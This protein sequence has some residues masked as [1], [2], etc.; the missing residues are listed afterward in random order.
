M[1]PRATLLFDPVDY[2]MTGRPVYATICSPVMAIFAEPGTCNS[3]ADWSTFKSTSIGP[4]VFLDVI[5]SNHCDPINPAMAGCDLLCGGVSSA[6]NQANYS[7]YA[8]AYFLALLKDDMAAAATFTQSVLAADTALRNTSVRDAPN[9]AIGPSDGGVDASNDTTSSPDAATPPDGTAPSDA[10]RSDAPAPSDSALDIVMTVDARSEAGNDVV[11][12]IMDAARE[13]SADATT[14][15]EPP[16]SDAGVPSMDSSLPPPVSDGGTPDPT[17]P[18]SPAQT[19][20]CDCVIASRPENNLP[21]SLA[22][23]LVGAAALVTRRARRERREQ[24][25]AR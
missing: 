10:M 7:R 5:G 15:P 9:C 17:T 20:G 13:A 25:R 23:I 16:A 21:R 2:Q 14:T 8:T 3:Q 1:K 19:S 22:A 12:P 24:R 6:Q 18:T 11:T 4:Q